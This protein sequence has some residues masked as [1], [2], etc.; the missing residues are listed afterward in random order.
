[1]GNGDI[2]RPDEDVDIGYAFS[3]AI[4]CRNLT[5]LEGGSVTG[6]VV[7]SRVDVKGSLNGVV[8]CEQFQALPPAFVRGTVFA[9]NCLTRD[10]DG[11]T[12]D[13]LFL[14]SSKR[15]AIFHLEPPQAPIN[16]EELISTAIEE[17]VAERVAPAAASMPTS[18]VETTSEAPSEKE[19]GLL[20]RLASKGL[21]SLLP[22]DPELEELLEPVSTPLPSDRSATSGRTPLPSLV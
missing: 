2:I 8:D 17:A 15:Q 11:R 5:V 14:Y 22:A 20:E 10:K 9:P 1:M 12:S 19:L 13:A 21:T 16:F 3:G 4:R 18:P 7:A 6:S